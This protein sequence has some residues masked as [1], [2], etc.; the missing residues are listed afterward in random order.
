MTTSTDTGQ[1]DPKLAIGYI[2]VSLA[3]EEMIS[4]ELQRNAVQQW[5]ARNNYRIVDWVEDLDKTG[6]NFKRK[7][8]RAVERIEAGEAEAIAVWKYSRFGRSREGVPLNLARVERAGGQLL[9]ATEDI[10]A[11]TAVGKFQRGMIFEFG[12]FE[13]DRAG[14]QWMETHE[15]R[16]S[17][18]LPATGRQR[19]GYIWHPRR[20]TLPDGKIQIQQERYEPD[21]TLTD[22]IT[23][24]YRRYAAGAGFRSLCTI[25]ADQGIRTTTGGLWSDSSLIIYMDSGFAA[26]YLRVHDP[27]CKVAPYKGSCPRHLLV[28]HPEFGHTAIIDEDL[29]QAYLSRRADVKTIPPHARKAGHP[30]TGLVFCGLC[31]YRGTRMRGGS[32]HPR[33]V[34]GQRRSKGAKACEGQFRMG[35]ALTDVVLA[36][37]QEV[38]DRVHLAALDASPQ[39]RSRQSE[40]ERT[41]RKQN[42]LEAELATTERAIK[43]HMRVYAMADDDG[44]E[45]E[46]LATLAGLRNQKTRLLSELAELDDSATDETERQMAA[47]V[48]V[49]E[50]LLEEWDTLEPAGINVILRRLIRAVVMERDG[51]IRVDPVWS[52]AM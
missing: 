41:A 37:V 12:A 35:K 39:Q 38:A 31:G 51:S 22:I 47:A 8:M 9:S 42:S 7:I 3:R 13:S 40:Q 6:R 26:G 29:W 44:L 2:R 28:R 16:R 23:D 5:A 11:S 14:E 4:P 21:P 32:G 25:L 1:A 20:I 24:L 17:H 27:A 15:W 34:C 43:R 19:F 52:A 49:A 50:G 48:P 46:F 45:A 30:L 33:F 10:D 18:G 36:W